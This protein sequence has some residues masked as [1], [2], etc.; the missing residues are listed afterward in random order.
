[1]LAIYILVG[2]TIGSMMLHLFDCIRKTDFI[3]V[4][5]EKEHFDIAIGDEF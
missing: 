5:K 1:M 2:L 3:P 4:L